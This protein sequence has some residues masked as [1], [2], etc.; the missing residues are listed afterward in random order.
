MSDHTKRL[1]RR[2]FLMTVGAGSA[3]ATAAAIVA[4]K[5]V[6]TPPLEGKDKRATR[7]YQSSEHINNY[8]RTTK[9]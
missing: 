5:S 1:S 9:V 6:S 2:N 4:T 3:A 7:G 8:Y